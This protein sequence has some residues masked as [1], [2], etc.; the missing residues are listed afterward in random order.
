ANP[1]HWHEALRNTLNAVPAK[2]C[3]EFAGLLIQHGKMEALKEILAKLISQHT[4]STELLL[5][6]AKDRNDSFA[7]ILG[8]EVFRAMLTAMER[9]QFNE[10]RSNRL[11]D[12]ILDDQDLLV[13]LIGSADLEGIKG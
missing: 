6:L 13:E 4:A 10:K 9:D 8:P 2:L 1:E 3:H 11:R 7:D 12:F 5:W